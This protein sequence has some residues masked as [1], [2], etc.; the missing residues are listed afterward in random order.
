M[1][2]GQ[3]QRSAGQIKEPP[4]AKPVVKC[5]D[6]LITPIYPESSLRQKNRPGGPAF[7]DEQG[8]WD[9]RAKPDR[10]TGAQTADNRE[11]A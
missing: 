2:G 11:G 1:G 10:L 8:S 4:P 7:E 5:F 3:Q 9:P 6:L